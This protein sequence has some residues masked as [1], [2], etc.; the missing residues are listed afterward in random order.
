MLA[1]Y[2][3]PALAA[4]GVL[5]GIVAVILSE[6]TPPTPPIPYLP[7]H[8]PF[9]YFIAA[10]GMVEAAS[11]DIAIGSPLTEI[12]EEVFVEPGDFVAKGAPLFRLKNIVTRSRL[13]AAEDALAVVQA[14]YQKTI[15]LPRP[16]DIPIQE[17]II[18]YRQAD[19]LAQ[20]SKFELIENLS[21]PKAISRD[22]YNQRKYN[23]IKAK[24][25][26]A[27]AKEEL[28]RMLAGAWIRDVEIARAEVKEARSN[29][30][31][32]RYEV[33]NSTIRAPFSGVVMRVDIHE[34]ELAIAGETIK[35][36]MIFGVIDPLHVR[37]DVDEEE[38]WRIIRGAPAVGF[39]RG[40]SNIH[41][42][43]EFI[44]IDPYLVPKR[45]LTGVTSELVDTR[46]LQIIYRFKR[47]D[48]PIYPGQLLNVY[49]EAKPGLEVP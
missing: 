11:E 10:S 18:S 16:E 2:V 4:L 19:Y 5:L 25:Q 22:E 8:P 31:T 26:L 46:V 27:E 30:E 17:S 39:V 20:Q 29:V 45:A 28:D 48:L 34:G 23:T 41:V 47:E 32:V 37:V 43:L 14:K 49:L 12:V 15:D 40:N 42:P 1:R 21:N 33:E 24:Y 44:R 7:P 6:R 35:S 13:Q 3:L 36:P 38:I 9:T